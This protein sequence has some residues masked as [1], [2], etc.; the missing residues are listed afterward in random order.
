M[1][2]YEAVYASFHSAAKL[3]DK[4]SLKVS[5]CTV[6]LKKLENTTQFLTTEEISD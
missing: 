2:N 1:H 3:K 4:D 6:F 5:G